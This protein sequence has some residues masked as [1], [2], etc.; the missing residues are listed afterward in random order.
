[1]RVFFA[2]T[3]SK[4]HVDLLHECKV[5][6]M[7]YSY[8]FI[9][10][11]DKLMALLEPRMPKC[12]ILDSGA[13][14]VWSNG[15]TIDID[16][17]AVFA[18]ELQDRL[19]SWVDYRIVNLDVLPGKFGER[20]TDKQREESAEQGW[21]NMLY[22]ESKGLKVIH[23]FHQHEDFKWLEK[24]M[25]HSD[26]IGISPAND[27]SQAEKD[28]WLAKCF[29]I[30]RDKIKTHG[31]AVTAAAQIYKYPFF[32]VDSSSWTAPARFGRVPIFRD[33]LTVG[34]FSYKNK[35][36]VL[37]YW[38]YIKSIG[39]DA[40]GADSWVERTRVAVKSYQKLEVIATKL[41]TSRGVIW[42]LD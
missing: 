13:F 40:I 4:Q 23:V 18:K 30:T 8:H 17:Y 37:K 35:N 3:P 14:S 15:G 31:F 42:D 16:A 25:A 36:E 7:L 9:K 39:I 12:L 29:S 34:S 41:W 24:M 33:D 32:S 22:L 6:R 27:L 2:C 38:E 28:R 26:Y 1:M 19:P 20:P 10:S 21:A 11:V 5:D